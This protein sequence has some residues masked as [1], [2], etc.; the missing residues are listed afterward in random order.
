MAEEGTHAGAGVWLQRPAVAG[1]IIAL[2]VISALLL[3]RGSG[4]L[5]FLD[6]ATWDMFISLKTGDA[7]PGERIVL[8]TVTE[9]DIAA[10]GSW[11]LS[12]AM[13][14]RALG[15]ISAQGA[16][17]IGLDMY[18][19]TPV[20][21]GTDALA[22]TF[23]GNP[24]IIGVKKFA[25]ANAPGV[26]PHPSLEA[27]GRIGFSDVVVDSNGIVRRGL[28][29]LD[30][31]QTVS[32]SLALQLALAYLAAEG[33]FPQ[34]G[35]PEPSHIRLGD[36]TIPPLERNDGPY[37]GADTA[38]Y[39]FLLDYGEGRQGYPAVTLS[40]L[41]DGDFPAD[42]FRDKVVILGV[43]AQSVK[44]IFFTPYNS[45]LGL[46]EG[47]AG[48]QVH[49]QITA[50][51]LNAALD[52]VRPPRTV[53]EAWAM[54]W[55]LL[56]IAAGVGVGLANISFGRVF[57]VMLAGL[58]VIVAAGYLA[59]M[60]GWWFPVMPPGL[61]WLAAA[62]I[63]T[64]Y[65][66]RYE[67]QQRGVLMNLFARHV[68]PDVADEIWRN[69]EQYFANGRL[70]SQKVCVSTLFC[71]I[72]KFTT[73][74]ERLD[75]EALMGWLNDYME[76]MATLIM[77]HNGIVDDYYGDAI[78]GDFGVPVIRT[79]REQ[80]RQDAENAVLCALAMRDRLHTINERCQ[81]AGLPHLRMRV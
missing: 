51:L 45:G 2:R 30:D 28:L 68:S 22:A 56:W 63:T 19:D 80:E 77:Q 67:R 32:Y 26:R 24:R 6:L 61:G 18:R 3:A 15:I 42:F 74:S 12:D 34:P 50:Q 20:P 66:S 35:D 16:R 37:H 59:F 70:R 53:P 11:P 57:L 9:D 21:P 14:D 13:L 43:S 31:R 58:A 17:V 64:A 78:K 38:G 10:L 33:I 27:A 4:G 62:G 41:L 36:V 39:Q 29:F 65:L 79:T 69:R 40:R 47:V 44:D 75:P 5:Q 8:V 46:D 49:A 72:E 23:A 55:A 73:V 54:L 60:R 76:E 81:Q 52:G 71:D 25:S 1:V 7:S 48:V